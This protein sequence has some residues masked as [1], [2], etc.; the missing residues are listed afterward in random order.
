MGAYGARTHYDLRLA[1]SAGMV[2]PVATARPP[3]KPAR[4]GGAVEV[5]VDLHDTAA[6]IEVQAQAMPAYLS[7][8][9]AVP[10]AQGG[11]M[12][13]GALAGSAERWRLS[14]TEGGG[15]NAWY[16]GGP[17]WATA[18]NRA[19]LRLRWRVMAVPPGGKLI[20][21]LTLK[22][23][24]RD[25]RTR[26][27]TTSVAARLIA[28]E[29]VID[30]VS[31]TLIENRFDTVLSIHGSGFVGLPKV[32]LRSGTEEVPLVDVRAVPDNPNAL[33]ATVPAGTKKG[34]Y[35]LRLENPDGSSVD[36]AGTITILADQLNF[37][38]LRK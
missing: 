3:S 29:P 7:L 1:T 5:V 20:I 31:P 18:G 14:V 17:D 28:D 25:G 23:V 38:L 16:A 11:G 6:A 24:G 32:F 15:V 4:V 35:I 30:D 19:V 26:T 21:P 22:V 8:I 34:N 13:S 9:E 36:Y 33:R 10:L 2:V 12:A 37:P 27:E